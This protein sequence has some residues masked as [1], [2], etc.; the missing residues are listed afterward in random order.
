[1]SQFYSICN[2]RLSDHWLLLSDYIMSEMW[3]LWHGCHKKSEGCQHCYVFRRDA[4]FEKDS[5]VVSKTSTF[6]L[7]IR[8]DRQGNWKIPS[9]TLMW[10]CF[11]SD[12]FIEEADEW[13]E[14]AWLMIK[15][16]SDLHFYMVTKRPERIAQCLPEDWDEGYE[17][18]TVCCTIEN[19]R[20]TDE[21]LPIFKELPIRHK[22]IICEPLLES[23]DFHDGLHGESQAVLGAGEHPA[24]GSELA[25]VERFA[26]EQFR[27]ELDG[28][29][30]DVVFRAGPLLPAMFQVDA[31]HQRELVR[32]DG[33]DTVADHPPDTLAV[34]D[35]VQFEIPVR[36]Q[37]IE[38]FRLVPLHNIE[39]VLFRKRRDFPENRTHP[40]K[41]LILQRYK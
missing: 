27:G 7:P 38:E 31:G 2:V 29:L 19:Q 40:N 35:E 33:L 8:R 5:N 32:T 26:G 17:N 20:R 16:R 13:R 28:D 36:M 22:A 39:A 6:N 4:E 12:F 3:N 23:I 41:Y 30:A 14:D 18:V 9:G 10:T 15:R 34:F 11:T 24:D 1:M 25:P 21:R 37:R